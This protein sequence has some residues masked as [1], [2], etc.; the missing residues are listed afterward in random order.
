MRHDHH[1]ASPSLL[2]VV[3]MAFVVV[4][5][6]CG[7]GGDAA[8]N[9]GLG[10]LLSSAT[11]CGPAPNDPPVAKT[12]PIQN[13][14]LDDLVTLDASASSDPNKDILTYK[15]EFV[16]KPAGSDAKIVSDT[17]VKPTFRADKVGIYAIKLVVSDGKLFSA[18]V[19]TIVTAAL[20]NSAPLAVAGPNQTV[21][22]GSAV[23]LDGR[24]STDTDQDRLFYT[25]KLASKPSTST[26]ELSE[27]DSK[28][29]F[30]TFLPDKSGPYI[31][32]LVVSDGKDTGNSFTVITANP[33]P[34]AVS[35]PAQWAKQNATV[36]LDA[37]LSTPSDLITAFK[38]V[39]LSAPTGSNA[40]AT[41]TGI[42]PTFAPNTYGTYIYR[43]TVTDG[44]SDSLPS[45]TVAVVITVNVSG[46]QGES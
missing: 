23:I 22:L 15:W 6:G 30:F 17:N 10:S 11:N 16:S 8:C 44:Y 34:V 14:K 20:S 2:R 35:G 28:A 46:L 38:W 27:A 19:E 7:G 21:T 24:N 29:G 40:P 18:A 42:Q 31:F 37:R 5:A 12:G 32:S 1:K 33:R 3:V 36:T 39:L 4:L 25:W 43:L 41:L 45:A 13:V 26:K 9:S